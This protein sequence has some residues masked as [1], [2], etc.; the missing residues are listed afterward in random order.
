M[1]LNKIEFFLMNNPVR[2]ALQKKEAQKMR[3]LSQLKKGAV[4]LEI[5]SGRGVGTKLIKKYFQPQKITAIDLDLKM[6]VIAKKRNKDPSITFQV[7][8]AAK[9]PFENKQFDAVFDFGIIHHIP[10]WKDCLKELK[11]VLKQ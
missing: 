8:D 11:R 4:V 6:I 3:A 7:G 10:N 2:A 9:L 1:K 5:G